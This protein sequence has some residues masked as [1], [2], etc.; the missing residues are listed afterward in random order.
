MA[1][2]SPLAGSSRDGLQLDT[3]PSLSEGDSRVAGYRDPAIPLDLSAPPV[4]TKGNADHGFPWDGQRCS[5][6]LWNDTQ[7]LLERRQSLEIVRLWR[8]FTQAFLARHQRRPRMLEG[9]AGGGGCT[10]GYLLAG[11]EVHGV[12]IVDQ[13]GY[14]SLPF[15][16]FHRCDLSDKQAVRELLGSTRPDCFFGSPPCQKFSS[17]WKMGGRPSSSPDLITPLRE[18]MLKHPDIP[19]VIENVRG[20]REALLDPVELT[21]Y[22]FG[23]A[24][25]RPR[26]WESGGLSLPL[27]PGQTPSS[28]DG[29]RHLLQGMLSDLQEGMGKLTQ[30]KCVGARARISRMKNG[31][32]IGFCCFGNMFPVWGGLTRASRLFHWHWAMDCPP[33]SM[34]A[35]QLKEA[36]PPAYSEAVGRCQLAALYTRDST[37]IRLLRGWHRVS[38]EQKAARLA[39]APLTQSPLAPVEWDAS[40]LP[41]TRRACGSWWRP[42]AGLLSL[43]HWTEHGDF[44]RIV[45][46]CPD[47]LKYDIPNSYSTAEALSPATYRGKHVLV[48]AP[49]HMLPD[50]ARA[51]ESARAA[52]P[53]SRLSIL[54]APCR[55]AAWWQEL[56]KAGYLERRPMHPPAAL[57]SSWIPGVELPPST[58]LVLLQMGHN[59]YKPEGAPARRPQRPP[60]LPKY[61][62]PPKQRLWSPVAVNLEACRW[63]GFAEHVIGYLDPARGIPVDFRGDERV[64]HYDNY[65]M[66]AEA[67]AHAADECERQLA[68]GVLRYAEPGEL[69]RKVHPAIVVPQADKWRYCIDCSVGVNKGMAKLPMKMC[70]VL[71]ACD[72]LGEGAVMVK[73]DLSDAFFHLSLAAAGQTYLGL[74]HPK[75]G[76]LL[77]AQKLIFGW[78]QSPPYCAEW[79]DEICAVMRRHGFN[80][81]SSFKCESRSKTGEISTRY[82]ASLAELRSH[83]QSEAALTSAPT[84][85]TS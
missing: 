26:L 71:D 35:D 38:M 24:T 81:V 3:F 74:R 64:E 51:A 25:A 47:L 75:T 70:H 42:A 54:T 18:V 79:T 14:T 49:A 76:E 59:L 34:T 9:M 4:R 1:A 22:L 31:V 36:I 48:V 52:E 50:I 45:G 7:F 83:V 16:H 19:Y 78:T 12:D 41:S 11:F 72:W 5:G 29:W 20:A 84:W 57:L 53:R 65:P 44:Q 6:G 27:Q 13:P 63:Y 62:T 82:V 60:D 43:L 10:R 66:S 46:C 80:C 23:L 28:G 85:T 67:Q 33:D 56:G 15:T 17:A 2:L 61:P 73:Q 69:I 55:E 77:V 58:D 68:R 37:A 21:G 40:V 39:A 8:P 32:K 30:G